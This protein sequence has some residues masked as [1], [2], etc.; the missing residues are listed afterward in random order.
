MLGH[1]LEAPLD[2][3]AVGDEQ[4]ELER[5]QIVP[6]ACLG[7]EAIGDREE[8]VDLTQ[9]PE[10]RRARPRHVLHADRCRRDLL[11]VDDPGELPEPVVGDRRHSDVRLRSG[12]RIGGDLGARIRERVEE[13]RLAG[14]RQT[15]DADLQGHRPRAYARSTTE[16]ASMP[17]PTR[18]SRAKRLT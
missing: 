11:R 2:V 5:L 4:L 18:P 13:R 10:Q 3:V 1:P 16:G 12:T 14:V 15:D 8:G 9:V 6:W 17:K 7:R